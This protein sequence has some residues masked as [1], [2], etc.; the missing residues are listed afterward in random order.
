MFCECKSVF[1]G[2][3]TR[4]KTA[5]RFRFSLVASLIIG[6]TFKVKE[7]QYL[8]SEWLT[9]RSLC[10]YFFRQVSFLVRLS[11]NTPNLSEPPSDMRQSLQPPS[12]RI[13]TIA[14]YVT[15]QGGNNL[16]IYSYLFDFALPFSTYSDDFV[17]FLFFFNFNSFITKH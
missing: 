4:L 6:E 3:F 15:D 2:L 5:T 17:E 10:S 9:H 8:L 16:S 13:Q 7:C 1:G 14:K 11:H 12:S